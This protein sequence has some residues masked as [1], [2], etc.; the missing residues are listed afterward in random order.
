MRRYGRGPGTGLRAL[1]PQA[2]E[3]IPRSYHLTDYVTVPDDL[4]PVTVSVNL[5][6]AGDGYIFIAPYERRIGGTPYSPYLLIVDGTGELVYHK[7][8]PAE[9]VDFKKQ[10]GEVLSYARA[11]RH[12]IM[13][14]TYNVVDAITAANGYHS[15][16][17]DFQILP[18]GHVLLLIYEERQIDMSQIAPG[19]YPDATVVGCR[20]Q[21]LDQA[22]DVV[23]EWSSFDHIPITDTT[24]SLLDQRIDYVHCNAIE[25]D[26]DGHLLL[27]CRDTDQVIKINRDTGD[28]LWRLGGKANQFEFVNAI[29]A[30]DV[31]FIKQH[32]VRRVANGNITLFDNRLGAANY[33]RAVEYQLDEVASLTGT[34][35]IATLVWEYRNTPDIH[36][37]IL[38]NAQRLPNGNTLIGWGS[39][40]PAVAE[41]TRGGAKVFELLLPLEMQNYRAF[42]FPWVGRPDTEPTLVVETENLTTTTLSYSW[43]GATDVA[44]YRVYGDPSGF[45]TTLLKVEPKTGFETTTV[46]TGLAD[47]GY[48]FRVVPLDEAGEPMIPDPDTPTPTNT[49]TPTVTPT[50]TPTPTVTPTATATA[51][52][53]ATPTTMHQVYLPLLW[54]SR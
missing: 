13:D 17:H 14:S 35:R 6:E 36:G 21:E 16:F 31:E 28:I 19:G 42:R 3:K 37:H 53:T 18:N 24:K 5:P 38:G 29:G 1:A 4:P 41:V 30:E 2:L 32:D 45:P 9:A 27:S 44:A 23:F 26:S 20:V 46:F 47:S 33:S 50:A 7:K 43:N 11:S 52:P 25:L 10:V 54:K 49:S 48:N 39:G 8:L 12:S 15:D 51:T 40:H 22:R 34:N